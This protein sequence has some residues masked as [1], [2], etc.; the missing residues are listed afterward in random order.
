MRRRESRARARE[1]LVCRQVVELVT[2]YL[3]GALSADERARFE[4]HLA[5]C[6]HCTEYL[7]E[8]R[9]TIA[10]V[11]RVEPEA[12]SAAARNDLVALYRGWRAE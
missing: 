5:G 3:E 4:A 2:D 6:P 12:L 7:R 11:G 1:Q 10:A 9:V 8:M